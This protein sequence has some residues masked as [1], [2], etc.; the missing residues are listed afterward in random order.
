MEMALCVFAEK[1]FDASSIREIADLA[2][3]NS[4]LIQYHFGGKEGLYRESLRHAFHCSPHKILTFTPPPNPSEPDAREKGIQGI[5]TF[6]AVTLEDFLT[7]HGKGLHMATEVEQAAMTVWSREMQ[8]PRPSMESFIMETIQ[9]YLN[10]LNGCISAIRPD[11]D[12]EHRFRMSFS[13][14][15]QILFLH[16]DMEM[17]RLIRGQAYTAPDLQSLVDHVTDFSLRGL[18]VSEAFPAQGA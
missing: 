15:S 2:K 4:A 12:D 1:G 17:I 16:R 9:P 8:E 11:L 13:I 6:I 5:R 7:C 3:A 10:Y 18:G 14:Q